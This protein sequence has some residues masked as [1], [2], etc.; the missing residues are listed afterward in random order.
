MGVF[1]FLQ[2]TAA[3]GIFCHGVHYLLENYLVRR[4]FEPVVQKYS[5]HSKGAVSSAGTRE[6]QC[7]PKRKLSDGD[8]AE[9]STK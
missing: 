3:G 7:N 1:L 2:L 4:I 5:V 8:V 9:I 6:A